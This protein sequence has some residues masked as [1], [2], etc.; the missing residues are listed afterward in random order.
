[1]DDPRGPRYEVVGRACD[2]RTVV[3]VMARFV[4]PLLIITVYEKHP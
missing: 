2:L 4:G 3:G 1:V